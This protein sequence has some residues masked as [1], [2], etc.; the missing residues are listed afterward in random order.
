MAV[1]F[2]VAYLLCV[3]AP[4]VALAF[5]DGSS[6]FH[7][8]TTQHQRSSAHMHDAT[9]QVGSVVAHSHDVPH[10]D[11][12]PGTSQSDSHSLDA[13][14]NCCGLF[15]VSAMPAGPAPEF[16]RIALV[17]PAVAAVNYGIAGRGPDRI[18]RPPIAL[19]PL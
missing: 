17:V 4:P 13:A 7:C 16:V 18:D 15:C 5:V 3:L 1:T 2:A 11:T 12:S 19:L 14:V 8:L 10:H 6:A 9:T